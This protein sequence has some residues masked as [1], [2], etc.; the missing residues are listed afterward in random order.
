MTADPTKTVPFVSVLDPA[1]DRAKMNIDEYAKTRDPSLIVESEGQKA[2]RFYLRPI[3]PAAFIRVIDKAG[4]QSEKELYAF[5]YAIE[6]VT[7]WTGPDGGHVPSWYPT[8]SIQLPSGPEKMCSDDDLGAFTPIQI[9]EIGAIAYHRSFLGPANVRT[10][11]LPPTL[12][13]VLAEMSQ[14]HADAPA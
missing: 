1:L 2:T 6:S 9:K 7:D 8:G 4:S 10:Y 14:S 12:G 3:P 5:M 13:V 11:P